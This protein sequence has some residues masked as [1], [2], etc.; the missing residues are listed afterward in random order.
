MECV[1]LLQLCNVRKLVDTEAKR[2]ALLAIGYTEVKQ[3]KTETKPPDAAEKPPEGA[4]EEDAAKTEKA[5]E[6]RRKRQA[7]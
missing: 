7:E 3:P 5:K 2:D 6:P 1:Y 4:A